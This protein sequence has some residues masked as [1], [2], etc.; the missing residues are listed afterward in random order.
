MNVIVVPVKQQLTSMAFDQ[1]VF[2]SQSVE[3]VKHVRPYFQRYTKQVRIWTLTAGIS[4]QKE[5]SIWDM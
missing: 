4:L 1:P 5:S 2:F 3:H